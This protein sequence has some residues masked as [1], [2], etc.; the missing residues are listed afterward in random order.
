MSMRWAC[1]GLEKIAPYSRWK[2]A[3]RVH[4][5]V[6]RFSRDKAGVRRPECTA[7]VLHDERV[8]VDVVEAEALG[9]GPREV[10]LPSSGLPD[11]GD[12]AAGWGRERHR[13]HSPLLTSA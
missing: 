6:M 10:R 3:W 13:A 4:V 1:A 5:K 8:A 7:A 2:R 9:E 12:A 11:D